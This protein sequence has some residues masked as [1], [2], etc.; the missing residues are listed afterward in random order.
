[1]PT[2]IHQAQDKLFKQSM[3]DLRV[4]KDFFEAHLPDKL[5][6]AISFDS[7]R[8]KKTSFIDENYKSTEADVLYSVKFD[9]GLGYL[10]LLCEQQSSP[11]PMMAFR[12][13]VYI[14]RIMEQHR[15]AYP[16]ANLPIVYPMV[17][18][19]GTRRWLSSRDLFDLFGNQKSLAKEIFFQ[20]FSLVDVQRLSDGELKKQK[21]A[22]LMELVLK[23]RRAVDFVSYF[24]KLLPWLREIEVQNGADFGKIVL[25]FVAD[26]MGMG[27]EVKTLFLQKA[28]E[29]LGEQLRGEAMT[30]ADAFREEGMELGMQQGMQLGKKEGF[31]AGQ[32]E[33]KLEMAKRLLSENLPLDLIQKITGLDVE[34]ITSL[35]L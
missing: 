27:K 13:L 3:S 35:V 4:A 8:L 5:K 25:K 33:A 11:E 20:P 29:H 28:E 19:S 17:L 15:K 10:Y 24:D 9:G 31:V 1:M 14:V 7:L 30:L 16:K 26:G 22:G 12:L 32:Q 21:W 18:Y 34:E 6:K 2:L 23:Y